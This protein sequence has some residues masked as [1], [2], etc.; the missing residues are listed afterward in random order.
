LSGIGAL[1]PGMFICADADALTPASA[2][3][4][5]ATEKLTFTASISRRRRRY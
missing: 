3:A 4:L 2:S 1:M 5:A